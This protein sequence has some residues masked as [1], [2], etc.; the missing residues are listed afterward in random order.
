MLKVKNTLTAKKEPFKPIEKGKIRM[1]VCGPTVYGPGHIGHARTYI[2]FDIIRRYLE[3]RKFRVKYVVNITD[4]HDDMIKTANELGIS[5]FELG[6]KYSEEFFKE[7]KILKV[8]QADVYP[9]VTEE[10]DE[11]I[12]L[13]EKLV[14]KKLAYETDDG[15]YFKVE[16][17]SDYGKLSGIKI[18]KGKTGTRIQTDKYEKNNVQDFVLWKKAKPNE[19]AWDSPWGKGRPGWHIECSAMNFHHLGEQIDIHCGA[20]DLSFPHHENEIAQSEGVTGKQFVKY[21]MHSGFLN[22]NEKKMSK[23]LG[24]FITIPELLK[25][26]DPRVFRFF[27]SGLHYRS[28]VNFSAKQI[29][30]SEKTLKKLDSFLKRLTE[31]KK[32]G[33][34]NKKVNVLIENAKK[35]FEKEMDDDFNLPNA[36]AYLFELERETN[37][38]EQEKGLTKKDALNVLNFFKK[39]NSFLDIFQFEFKEQ[40]L[41]QEEMKLIKKRENLRKEKKWDEADNIRKLLAKKGILLDD[42]QKGTKW[43]KEA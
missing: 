22:V 9:R 24:N 1:Y 28:P 42:T 6:K 16:K 13:I 17:F 10:I 41:S 20:E 15:V 7:M 36:W 40:K 39:I 29:K 4:V 31:I 14:Q 21:W 25:T 35:G 26:T 19:P 3:Y 23:S 18:E 5:I 11:I 27:V 12:K 38:M 43:R 8:K 33:S 30:K 37:K 34:E 32:T 2:A